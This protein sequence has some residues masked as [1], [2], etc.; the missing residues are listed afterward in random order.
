MTE[1]Q[2]KNRIGKQ[3][4]GLNVFF[5]FVLL[6]LYI[7]GGFDSE[8][9]VKIG[10]MLAPI[11]SL[12]FSAVMSYIIA[13][14]YKEAEDKTAVMSGLFSNV[15]TWMIW[16]HILSLLAVFIARAFNILE[17]TEV[18]MYIAAGIE[19]FFGVYVGNFLTKLF[20]KEEETPAS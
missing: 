18:A 8:D 10:Q 3:I 17:N 1:N 12:Y 7:S 6:I 4:I 16:L 11:H 19:T 20:K 5:A 2:Y 9:I 13:N 14:P 15:A